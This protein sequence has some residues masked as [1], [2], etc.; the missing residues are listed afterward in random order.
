MDRTARIVL[1]L[2]F[3]FLISWYYLVNRIYPPKKIPPRPTNAVLNVTNSLGAP[4]LGTNVAVSGSNGIR[5]ARTLTTIPAGTEQTV[6]F[7]NEFARYTFSSF[8][9]GIKA[10]ELK[11]Y[12]Q[13]VGCQ[14]ETNVSNALATLNRHAPL[15]VLALVGGEEIEGDGAFQLTKSVTGVRAEKVLTNGLAVIK[16]FQIGTNYMINASVRLENRSAQAAHV[17]TRELVIGTAAPMGQKDESLHLGFEWYNGVKTEQVAE[18]WFA[19][20]GFLWFSG[21]PRTEYIA[22]ASNVYWGAVNNQFFTIIAGSTNPVSQIVAHRVDLPAPTLAEVAADPHAYVKP[23]GFQAAFLLPAAVVP[24]KQAL[25]EHFEIFAGP[26][27]YKILSRVGDDF[28]K[29]M[30]FNGFF[31]FFSKALLLSMNALHAIGLPYGLAIIAITVI[32]KSIFWPLTRASTRSMKRM[33]ALQPQIKAIQAKYKE[34]PQKMNAKVMEFMKENKVSPLGGCLPMLLQIPVFIGFYQM[35]RSAIE[36]RGAHLLW[37]CDLSQPDTIFY[38]PGLNFPVNPL[39]LIMGATQIWQAHMTPPSPGMDP[40]QQKMM[41]YMPL[42][43]VVF[44]YK[45]S[46]GLTLYWTVQNLL[47]ILQMKLTRD[48]PATTPVAPPAPA[49]PPRKAK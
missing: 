7:E 28:D 9:G 40:V 30:G 12:P 11:G 45:F 29:V 44:L 24:A 38:I 27:E 36:L 33:A 4:N 15:P 49:R 8:G 23:F 22:G 35:L 47:S 26:K 20:K 42:M 18:N 39:P 37:A 10:V 21:T 6:L 17:P 2:S 48:N 41:K 13:F 5:A 19:N 43:M 32:I 25:E 34:E 14:K 3:A 1:V 46:A 31:G 16:D